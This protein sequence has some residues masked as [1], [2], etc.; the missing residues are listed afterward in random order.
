MVKRPIGNDILNQIIGLHMAKQSERSIVK[1][2]QSH[3][4]SKTCVHQAIKRYEMW[5]CQ[6]S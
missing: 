3:N 6:A 5:R 2:L 1:A 4:I